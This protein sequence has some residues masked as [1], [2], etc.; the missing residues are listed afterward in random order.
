M[1]FC[2]EI[3]GFVDDTEEVIEV[4]EWMVRQLIR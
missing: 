1:V 4:E 3:L 2:R